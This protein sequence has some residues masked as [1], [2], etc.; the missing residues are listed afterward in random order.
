MT[1]YQI[2]P[3]D[4][5]KSCEH[6]EYLSIMCKATISCNAFSA[7]F[8]HSVYESVHFMLSIPLPD[9]AFDHEM[10]NLVGVEQPLSYSIGSTSSLLGLSLETWPTT[11][12]F[13][14]L[15][16][17]ETVTMRARRGVELSSCKTKLVP[18]APA[19]G[20]TSGLRTSSM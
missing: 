7:P 15:R 4:F 3:G 2:R 6:R 5:V 13:Q 18:I 20:I 19:Y 1:G 16:L 11:P 12:F 9:N 14:F 10:W 17:T 8:S